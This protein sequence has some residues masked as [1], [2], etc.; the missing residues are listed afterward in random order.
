[1]RRLS[2]LVSLLLAVQSINAV[3]FRLDPNGKQCI[4]EDAGSDEVLIYVQYNVTNKPS[5]DVKVNLRVRPTVKLWRVGNAIPVRCDVKTIQH[6][7]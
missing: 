5:D 4:S 2:Q 3:I 7:H 6:S 1:M